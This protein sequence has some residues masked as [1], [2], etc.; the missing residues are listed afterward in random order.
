MSTGERRAELSPHISRWS[1]KVRVYSPTG[2]PATKTTARVERRGIQVDAEQTA[3]RDLPPEAGTIALVEVALL[4]GTS[5]E[6]ALVRRCQISAG[7]HEKRTA[8]HRR[9]HDA[10]LQDTIGLSLRNQWV[11]R[12]ADE[13]VGQ[14]LRCIERAR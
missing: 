13:I 2:L 5:Q 3:L 8:S 1:R 11:Q 6:R 9:I 14:R 4:T 12:P 7:R 10:Q